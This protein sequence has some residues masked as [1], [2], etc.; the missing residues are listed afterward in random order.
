M[1]CVPAIPPLV[2]ALALNGTVLELALMVERGGEGR[3]GEGRGGKW[4]GGDGRGG[5]GRGRK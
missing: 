5:E 4:R 3:G 1:L 2:T